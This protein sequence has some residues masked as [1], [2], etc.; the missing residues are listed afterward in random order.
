MVILILWASRGML[1]K[2]RVSHAPASL[3]DCHISNMELPGKIKAHILSCCHLES[4]QSARHLPFPLQIYPS[5]VL[6]VGPQALWLLVRLGQWGASQEIGGRR[7]KMQ[8]NFSC[9]L[10]ERLPRAAGNFIKRSRSRSSIPNNSFWL[11]VSL[12]LSCLFCPSS[13][14]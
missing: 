3:E 2:L 14:Y 11:L 7:V 9:S 1:V 10:T 12:S 13:S 8:I 5:P 4:K 6:S